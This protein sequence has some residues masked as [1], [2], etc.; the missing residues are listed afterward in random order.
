MYIQLVRTLALVALLATHKT[1]ASAIRVIHEKITVI[2]NVDARSPPN[3]IFIL[4]DDI[5]Y[6][7]VG[8]NN[9][10]IQTP[11]M[12]K[13][14]KEGVILD[15]FYAMPLCTPSRASLLTGLYAQQLGL[16]R[17]VLDFQEPYGVP[18]KYKFLPQLLKTRG[19]HSHALGKWHLGFCDWRYTPTYRGFDTFFGF[20]QGYEENYQHCLSPNYIF[21]PIIQGDVFT[22][23]CEN[24]PAA[25]REFCGAMIGLDQVV[26]NITEALK[27]HNLY[28]NSIVVFVSDNGG[29]TTFGGNNFP[30]RGN[31]GSLFEGGTR[32]PGFINSPLLKKTGYV[33]SGLF[34]I[35]D[36]YTTF[37][38]LAGIKPNKNSNLN[39]VNQW[40]SVSED[41]PSPR[42]EF[43]YLMDIIEGIKI[44]A[45]RVGDYK[46]I[47]GPSGGFSDEWTTENETVDKSYDPNFMTH[48]DTEIIKAYN[49]TDLSPKLYNLAVDPYE[50]NNLANEEPEKLEELRERFDYY[51]SIAK[52]A[53][54]MDADPKGHPDKFGGIFTSGWC[55]AYDDVPV[56]IS[57]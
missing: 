52:P 16:Q 1:E 53:V 46:L 2:E 50:K 4:G 27:R 39:G 55:E 57:K 10:N 45:V 9:P 54:K 6:N 5:G 38:H 33:Y 7:D 8:W 23:Q 18:L 36:W 44:G 48:Y 40:E 25:R 17:G 12:N 37:L 30:L 20:Y 41:R 43:P 51:F 47:N 56:I 24:Q 29:S 22:Q 31:K 3:I 13:L 32:V 49:L 34:H 11:H 28:D 14:A 15:H 42:T 21:D 35:V 26:H 19:Y